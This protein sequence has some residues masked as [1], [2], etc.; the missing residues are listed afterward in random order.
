LIISA[1][2]PSSPSGGSSSAGWKMNLTLPRSC[3]HLRREGHVDLFRHRQGIH[4]GAQRDHRAGQGAF[5]QADHAGVR[6]FRVDFIQAELA[7]VRRDDGRGA[8]LAVAELGMLVE[9]APPGDDLRLDLVR[10]GID[11]G[12]RRTGG[13]VVLRHG[14]SLV[15]REVIVDQAV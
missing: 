10:C 3:A 2:P 7:Q 12:G 1:A 4:V 11:P 5:Q 14:V 13:R 15:R 9:I 8:R 6:H